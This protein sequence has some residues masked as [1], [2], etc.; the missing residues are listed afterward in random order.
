VAEAAVSPL[1]LGVFAFALGAAIGSFLN[2]VIHRVPRGLSIVRPGSRCPDCG[3]PI[4]ALSNLPI[5]SY[6]WQR[7]RCRD[8]HAR[9]SP[10][11]PAV[12]A[13]C[14][15][16]FLA[17]AFTRPIDLRLAIDAALGAALIAVAFIDVDHRIIPNAI[18][19]PGIP[20]GLLAAWLSPPPTLGES[21]A[22]LL[23]VGGMLYAVSFGY[24]VATKRV[25]LGMGDVKLMGMLGSF[26]GLES[27]LGVLVMGSLLGL[28]QAGWLALRGRAGR[29]TQIPFGP[30]L[31]IAALAH[32]FRSDW[33]AWLWGLP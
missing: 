25:G 27:A 11:Y 19:L 26:L 4:R 8:C 13:L 6:L 5:L 10:R 32:L 9:I 7:G 3:A 20:L 33:V 23:V 28:A 15:L 1:W 22:G 12:E 29:L 17:L 31:V 24:E 2:V 14:G 21:A 16:L 30:A 18:T